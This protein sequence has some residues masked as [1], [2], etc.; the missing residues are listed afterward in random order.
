[1]N[2]IEKLYR[3]K[4]LPFGE[5]HFESEERVELSEKLDKAEKK[6]L[7]AFPECSKLFEQYVDAQME[8]MDFENY[9]EFLL[10]FKIG[11]QIMLEVLQDIK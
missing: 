2:I 6:L 3:N 8:S 11:A 10:G 9:G 7:E 5:I 4:I 1:M